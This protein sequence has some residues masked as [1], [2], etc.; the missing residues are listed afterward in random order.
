MEINKMNIKQVMY[1]GVVILLIGALVSL[2]TGEPNPMLVSGSII[3]FITGTIIF[4]KWI[5]T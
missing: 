5:T 1:C 2:I 4:V 3:T